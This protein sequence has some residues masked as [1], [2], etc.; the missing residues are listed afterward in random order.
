MFEL[1][2][3]RVSGLVERERRK[4]Y[5]ASFAFQTEHAPQYQEWMTI[6]REIPQR[7]EVKIFLESESEESCIITRESEKAEYTSFIEKV[8][9]DDEISVKVEIQKSVRDDRFSIYN[10]KEFSEDLLGIP[11][12]EAMRFFALLFGETQR[13]IIFELFRGEDIFYTKT[14]FFLPA[15]KAMAVSGFD[16]RQRLQGYIL[17]L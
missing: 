9:E 16:R 10:F 8:L 12:N 4:V 13:F 2:K 1:I 15:G 6:I 11:L 7:D 14:M 5:E 17:F 3:D